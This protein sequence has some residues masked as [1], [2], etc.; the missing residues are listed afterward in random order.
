M[1]QK[2]KME[3]YNVHVIGHIANFTWNYYSVHSDM[4]LIY[5]PSTPPP[6]PT[7]KKNLFSMISKN[8]YLKVFVIIEVQDKIG[9]LFS[10]LS[11]VVVILEE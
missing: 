1:P 6:T 2:S 3:I 8:T 9:S 7:P 4:N 11:L 5:T 10:I